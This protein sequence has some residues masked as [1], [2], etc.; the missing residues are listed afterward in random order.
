M[1]KIQFNKLS[2]VVHN[3]TA[4]LDALNE[5]FDRIKASVEDTLS[6]SGLTPNQMEQVLDMGGQRLTN[7][8]NATADTDALTKNTISAEI[9][10]ITA[11]IQQIETLLPQAKAALS[12]YVTDVIMPTINAKV[13]EAEDAAD[14]AETA[15][16][17]A[18]AAKNSILQDPNFIAVSAAL[19][20]IETVATNL[21]TITAV[22]GNATNINTVAGMAASIQTVINNLTAIQN[23][24]ENAVKSYT[25]AEGS[26]Q[27][28]A[29]LGGVHSAKGW[30][31]YA[32]SIVDIQP[33]SETVTGITRYATSAEAEAM[34]LNTV[35]ITPAKLPSI[36]TKA[37]T[38][39]SH[40]VAVADWSANTVTLNVTGVTVNSNVFVSPAGVL[41]NIKAYA[42][43]NVFCSAIGAGTVTLT[44]ENVPESS[45]TVIVG[46]I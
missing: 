14:D 29:V 44:C 2:Q 41:N 16:D 6:R 3:E 31:Q 13:D 18:I 21:A 12:Q 10:R 15:R 27:A 43:A 39:S 36:L 35:A 9:A 42:A 26:D 8:G 34:S 37:I 7:I 40:T 25:W 20:D 22:A 30:A 46:V 11:A 38:S 5:N 28:V 4:F 17:A 19:D 24:A 32:E 23:A 1:S 45:L 33:S